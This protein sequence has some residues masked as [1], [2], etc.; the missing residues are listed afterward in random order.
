MFAGAR[1][2]LTA[3]YLLIIMFISVSFSVM[4][5]QVLTSEVER[6]TRIQR[7]RI[8]RRLNEGEFFPPDLHFQGTLPHSAFMDPELV[9]ET[10]HRLLLVL[11]VVNGGIL[12]ASSGLG[13]ILA[14]RTL[15]PI[16][17]M[18]DEQN[19]FI[20]DSSHEL[21][22]PL[23]SL[24]SAM[25]V[26]LREKNLTISGA[27]TLISES[28]EEVNKLQSLSDELL[29]LA[30][31]QKPNGYAKFEMLSLSDLV[32]RAIRKITPVAKQKD[33]I[34]QNET[35]DIKF[36]G[37]KY[38]LSDLLVI[39]LDN[40]VKYSPKKKSI[41]ITSKKTNGSLAIS[42]EDQ[43]IGINEKDILHIFDRFF[44]ADTARLKTEA[45][46]YGLGL[47]IAKKIVDIH[48]GSISAKSKPREGSTF[49]VHLPLRQTV[50]LNKPPFFS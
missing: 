22:T 10:K 12:V 48:H 9:A 29:Q 6:L 33:I 28:I 3:W 7:L 24:K 37:N 25:E 14:G 5:Y 2:K 39:L 23:T 44:R 30:Q 41:K 17:D 45:P 16:K 43:G 4:I 19:R 8:E 11:F 32:K 36:E 40:A 35:Q 13:Y 15:K 20:T 50:R 27:K 42:V 1:F 31:Y 38:G 21:R 26:S 47:S 34:I 18:V 49:T 46:G